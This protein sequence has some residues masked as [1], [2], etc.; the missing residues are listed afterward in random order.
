MVQRT[1]A[2]ITLEEEQARLDRFEQDRKEGFERRNPGSIYGEPEEVP[3]RPKRKRH[4]T[5]V[6]AD[7]QIHIQTYW[8]LC[9]FKKEEI[10]SAIIRDFIRNNGATF[11]AINGVVRRDRHH[12]ALIKG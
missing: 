12:S 2:Q 6:D 4:R 7:A 11:E 10:V 8:D 1:F 5:N 3:P 9:W